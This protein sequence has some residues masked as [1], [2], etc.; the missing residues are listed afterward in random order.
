MKRKKHRANKC[1]SI[2]LFACGESRR[3]E[4]R[5]LGNVVQENK[6]KIF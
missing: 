4:T 6:N 2:N 1:R 3:T 5:L